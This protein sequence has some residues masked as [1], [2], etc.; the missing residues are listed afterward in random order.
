MTSKTRT[1]IEIGDLKGVQFQCGQC[2]TSMDIAIDSVT[3]LPLKCPICDRTWM[4]PNR[5]DMAGT[6]IHGLL[7][8]LLVA[9]VAVR[10][11]VGSTTAPPAF[12]LMLEISGT[13]PAKSSA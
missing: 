4:N 12:D 13:A 6:P 11:A 10:N 5:G 9:L 7:T 8:Q 1:Y 3:Q 2:K